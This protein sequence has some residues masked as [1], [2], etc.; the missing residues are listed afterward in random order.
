[1]LN[2]PLMKTLPRLL[3]VLVAI[4]FLTTC[5]KDSSGGGEN[6]L[7]DELIQ[8]KLKVTVTPE[9]SGT[10]SNNEGIYNKGQQVTITATPS[11]E[12]FAFKNWT[13]GT[14]GS[15]N[16][17]TVTMNSNKNITAN[18][19]EIAPVYANGEGEIGVL[20]GTIKIEDENSPL[21]G[22]SINIPPGSIQDEVTI[23]ITHDTEATII[24]SPSVLIARF[25]PE[26]LTFSKPVTI[27]IPYQGDYDNPTLYY[28]ESDSTN[29]EKI[30]P[31]TFNKQKKTV[32]AEIDHFSKYF[33]DDY[34]LIYA[35]VELIK[36]D[37][38]S[39]AIIKIGGNNQ[40]L[41][42]IPTI[43]LVTSSNALSLTKGDLTNYFQT[44]QDLHMTMEVKLV[45]K[46]LVNITEAKTEF[47]LKREGEKASGYNLKI[48]QL[49]PSQEP[50]GEIGNPDDNLLE[51]MFDG[52]A[53]VVPLNHV[54]DSSENY[55]LV[56]TWVMSNNPLGKD[57]FSTL[58]ANQRVT[59][60]YKIKTD[61]ITSFNLVDHDSDN[62]YINDSLEPSLPA[63]VTRPPSEV[64]TTSATLNGEIISNGDSPINNRGF[65][66]SYSGTPTDQDFNLLVET[67]SSKFSETVEFPEPGAT[68]YYRAW[69]QNQLGFAEGAVWSVSAD[70]IG[71][72]ITV[73]SPSNNSSFQTG[74]IVN[75]TGAASDT[76]GQV[77]NVKI[78]IDDSEVM[79]YA[80]NQS[81][82]LFAYNWDS[83]GLSLGMHEIKIEAEDN[84]NESSTEIVEVNISD[85]NLA[86][87][88]PIA[89]TIWETGDQ[90]VEIA[91]NTG[92]LG[93][94]VQIELLW[95]GGNSKG[96][97]AGSTPND[98]SFLE[99]GVHTALEDRS[100]YSIKITSLQF[101]DKSTTS[102]LFEIK[103]ASNFA[104]EAP[105][106]PFPADNAEISEN[107][108]TLFW[109]ANDPEGDPLT[110]DV[111]FG[112]TN[113]PP[114]ADSGENLSNNA[115][116]VTSLIEGQT[117]YWRVI[118][119]DDK[120]NQTTSAIWN[121]NVATNATGNLNV[122][123]Q[124]VLN[125]LEEQ[126]NLSSGVLE[127]HNFSGLAYEMPTDENGL[128]YFEQIKS[129]S[130]TARYFISNTY[131]GEHNV[132]V[133]ENQTTNMIFVRNSPYIKEIEVL[134]D[135]V[136]IK[137][138]TLTYSGD[139]S[140]T[141][142]HKVIV[143]NDGPTIV[144]EVN[145]QFSTHRP[146][147]FG[148]TDR[149]SRNYSNQ[150]FLGNGAE[151]VLEHSGYFYG[152]YDWAV[153][154]LLRGING[155]RIA[156]FPHTILFSVDYL[157][158]DRN[159]NSIIP[160]T[161]NGRNNNVL[162]TVNLSSRNVTISV[163]DHGT[164]DG[165]IV[166]IYINGEIVI[167]ERTL[168]GPQNKYSVTTT[169]DYN[170][171]NYLLLYAHNE[172]S[173]SPNTCTFS[174]YDGVSSEE[175]TL[176]SN[177]EENGAVDLI[178]N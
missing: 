163:W 141:V 9:G 102:G 34:S 111:Y 133:K 169:L 4:L 98:G 2:Q 68:I 39:K 1:M 49:Q 174:I 175:F 81:N 23:S 41:E 85:G 6:D 73:Q 44:Y 139:T 171:Y 32:T 117:Y 50:G 72:T 60:R 159:D 82:F 8:Y 24:D 57:G 17:V 48:F 25:E 45:K 78:F 167:A 30:P 13:G 136:D 31:V 156:Y 28:F 77:S 118:A 64:S 43:G 63:V 105:F 88:Q 79:S 150:T 35:D 173:V 95:D 52:S 80:P 146:N 142:D 66:Y 21:N 74:T 145:L 157:D 42:G 51:K 27:T 149:F 154:V 12:K 18:F 92:D 124:N 172:G 153:S 115:F 55:F 75:I 56:I 164:I 11:A 53:L 91:W 119:R 76:D 59:Y 71:P 83:S 87:T 114:L 130:Y 138:E 152:D 86:I 108:I 168:E 112:T 99:Y 5:S 176:E 165:D 127:L 121:F 110:Y 162:G 123:V 158:N 166:S 104:P 26:G 40:G 148:F 16:S 36:L 89:S 109:S 131:W 129:G 160:P 14:T 120:G 170:G 122:T 134:R 107:N 19:Q 67:S 143:Q 116:D 106:D 97:I 155:N 46:G 178:V 177:L 93:G 29:I 84:D 37:N 65:Y 7:P 10:V 54:I 90:N 70:N 15:T 33:A 144:G 96:T 38:R 147:V 20:G 3:F 101:P 151:T 22:T 62:N 69:A 47:T 137:G 61:L 94:D 132:V 135:G 161:F 140:P 58:A 128:A 100:D 125:A 113:D 126:Y 103:K